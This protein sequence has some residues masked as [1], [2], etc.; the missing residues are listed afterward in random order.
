MVLSL[1]CQR[2]ATNK[3]R[4]EDVRVRVGASRLGVETVWELPIPATVYISFTGFLS[5]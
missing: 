4:A 3:V 2:L 1:L 5:L